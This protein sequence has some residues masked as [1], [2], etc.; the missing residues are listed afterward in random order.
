MTNEV[1]IVEVKFSGD[2][3]QWEPTTDCSLTE[4]EASMLLAK[5]RKECPDDAFRV[6]CYRSF[7]CVL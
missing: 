1:F 7:L 6:T 2:N 5:W 4:R 3:R